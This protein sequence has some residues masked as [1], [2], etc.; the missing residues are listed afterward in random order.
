MTFVAGQTFGRFE[1]IRI[2]GSGSF[3]NVW[4]A[5]QTGAGHFRR[6]VAVKLLKSSRTD[7]DDRTA[8]EQEARLCALLD[9]PNIVSVLGIEE[10]GKDLAIV[11]EYVPGGTLRQVIDR[12][13]AVGIALPKTVILALA[14]DIA[15]GLAYAH[16]APSG[17]SGPVIHRDLKPANILLNAVGDAKITDFGIAK[18][19]GQATMT[20]TGTVKGTPS[21]TSPEV[22]RGNRD[23]GPATDLF[24]LGCI[25]YELVTFQRLFDSD[26]LRGLFGQLMNRSPRDEVRD[27]ERTFPGLAP[28]AFSLLQ[29]NPAER[30]SDGALIA[31]SLT[32]LES[33]LPGS[34]SV[35]TFLTLLELVEKPPDDP[36]AAIEDLRLP[37][38]LTSD[39][40]SLVQ[41]I[42]SR[43]AENPESVDP[44][45]QTITSQNIFDTTMNTLSDTESST[46]GPSGVSPF[47]D[48]PQP[49][50]PTALQ[51]NS[52][53]RHSSSGQNAADQEVD[54]KRGAG[55]LALFV[56]VVILL[57]VAAHFLGIG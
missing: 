39:W 44:H 21:Y 4:L 9:H 31:E 35:G 57:L 43:G 47:P 54:P 30:C 27:I 8:L 24:P 55:K 53:G 34:P 23:F 19:I 5:N 3:A 28:V 51:R 11:M 36:V 45:A 56:F 14:R 13:A 22:W 15:T 41:M 48:S 40:Q 33:G 2:L 49:V 46:S 29:R 1:P 18:V 16:S 37:E 20:A 52:R 25:L 26:S 6:K 12:S 38:D 17:L 42:L 32:Q 50:K 10:V 7:P